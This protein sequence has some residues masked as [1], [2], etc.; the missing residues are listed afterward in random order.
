MKGNNTSFS[1]HSLGKE[2]KKTNHSSSK[3]KRA[4]NTFASYHYGNGKLQ[5]YSL[6]KQ[7]SGIA[8]LEKCCS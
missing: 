4:I 2:E 5:L 1:E 6:N 7:I 3:F 8:M